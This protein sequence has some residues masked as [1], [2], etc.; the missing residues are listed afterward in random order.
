[1]DGHQRRNAAEMCATRSTVGLTTSQMTTESTSRTVVSTSTR[2]AQPPRA[3]RP[4]RAATRLAPDEAPELQ[5]HLEEQVEEQQRR[6]EQHPARS[7]CA[8]A[9]RR[10]PRRSRA[11]AR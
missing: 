3:V 10:S 8:E 7:R 5:Q 1:M 6:D 2:A 11:A 4:Q 9:R